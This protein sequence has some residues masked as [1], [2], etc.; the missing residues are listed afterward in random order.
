MVSA[1]TGSSTS[2]WIQGVGGTDLRFKGMISLAFKGRVNWGRSR[3]G[4]FQAEEVHVQERVWHLQGEAKRSE[5]LALRK[6]RG[7]WHRWRVEN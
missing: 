7:A 5:K 4:A 6:Q 3:D 1:V 2:F